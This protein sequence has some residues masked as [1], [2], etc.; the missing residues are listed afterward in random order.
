MRPNRPQPPRQRPHRGFQAPPLTLDPL[1]VI[2]I[3]NVAF[4]LATLVAPS[5]RYPWG[6]FQYIVSD[7]V[8]YYLGLIPYYLSARPWTLVTAMF[9]HANFTHILFNMIALFFFGR[10]LKFFVGDNRFLFVYFLG[11]IVGNLLFVGLN[12]NALTLVVG[13][14]GAIYAVAGALVVI[15]PRMRILFWGIVPMPMWLFVVVFLGIL[16]V[17]GI[18]PAGIA[19]QAHLGGLATG[20][21]VGYFYRRRLRLFVV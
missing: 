21:A 2:I 14:S 5:G 1:L 6:D 8:T 15:R 11:G 18:A 10:A 4:Y 7:K 13:A 19:W 12:A 20:L 3:I 16:A 17:P 9:I